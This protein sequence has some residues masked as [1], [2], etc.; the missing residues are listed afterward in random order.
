MI[1]QA[2]LRD[3]VKILIGGAPVDQA[4]VDSVGADGLAPDASAAVRLT[5]T[6]MGIA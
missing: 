5:K 6:V 1:E 3:G 2:G 4:M